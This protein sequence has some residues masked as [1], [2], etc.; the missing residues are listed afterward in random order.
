MYMPN[1]AKLGLVIGLGLVIAVAVVYF[2]S[3]Q[4]HMLDQTPTA[5]AVKR[6]LPARGQART[7]RA[8]TAVQRE[9]SAESTPEPCRDTAAEGEQP[10]NDNETGEKRTP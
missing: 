4:A 9:E 6:T 3:E 5:S 2:R 10:A 8:R 7:V 1:D